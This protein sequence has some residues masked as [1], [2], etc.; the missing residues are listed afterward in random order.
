MSFVTRKV[1]G[2]LKNS[3]HCCCSRF[4]HLSM[5]RVLT[6]W[7]TSEWDRAG[8]QITERSLVV[9]IDLGV[10]GEMLLRLVSYGPLSGRRLLGDGIL[11]NLSDETL[12]GWASVNVAW[13]MGQVLL[14]GPLKE[15]PVFWEGCHEPQQH[16]KW[17]QAICFMWAIYCRD[18]SPACDVRFTR[19]VPSH[20]CVCVCG[21]H[22]VLFRSH[23]GRHDSL[24]RTGVPHA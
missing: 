24:D 9:F 7:M 15:R 21:R 4:W 6:L 13:R 10:G 23:S 16:Q 2:S 14:V 22:T 11:A 20:L 19:V 3:R 8:A 1:P 18:L 12:S 5:S 17:I